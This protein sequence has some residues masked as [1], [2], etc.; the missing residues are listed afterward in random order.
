MTFQ[1][2]EFAAFLTVAAFI[3]WLAAERFKRYVLLLASYVFYAT[4]S[5][6]Y[7]ALLT[8]LTIVTHRVG[9]II[10]HGH[11]ERQ[12][13]RAVGFAIVGLVMVLAVFKYWKILLTIAAQI[14]PSFGLN[15][16]SRTYDLI[17]PIG[18]S[19]YIFKLISY[20]LDVYWERLPAQTS[21][22]DFGNYVSFFPQI[23]SGPIQRAGDFFRQHP[24]THN[25]TLARMQRGLRLIVFGL[26]Q[27]FVVADRIGLGVDQAFLHPRD[28]TSGQLLVA[29]YLFPWQLY[30]DFSGLTDI[31]IG[32]GR[33]FDIESPKN[34]DAPFFAVDIADFWRRW[35]ITLTTW[36]TDYLFTPLRLKLRSWG[37]L[38][39]AIAVFANMIAIGVWHGAKW[40]FVL[41]GAS[42]GILL[43]AA[44]LTQRKRNQFYKRHPSLA[45]A[46][47]ITGPLLTF[48]LVAFSFILFRAASVSEAWHVFAHALPAYLHPGRLRV[49]IQE[50]WHGGSQFAII[51]AA[52]L[53]MELCHLA[54][55]RALL[56][57]WLYCRPLW[58]RWCVYYAAVSVVLFFG[59]YTTKTFIYVQF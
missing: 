32:L 21:L 47:R 11:G 38:G 4:W 42:S 43:V 49:A 10:G 13:R 59:I 12:A 37:Q 15:H 22:I 57:R 39:L 17:A 41:F 53:T 54:R 55:R 40:T 14:G 1:S 9:L 31:A 24:G 16:S 23:L 20:V 8:I 35:H 19:Y 50:L 6:P 51:V 5:L 45:R 34:F 46:R 28:S 52:L 33:L 18:I 27:K 25:P 56:G 36:L 7:T 48:H 30:A 2:V 3:Y 58:L 44:A 29:V 26:F